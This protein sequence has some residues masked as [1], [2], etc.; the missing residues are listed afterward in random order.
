MIANIWGQVQMV[1]SLPVQNHPR[2][3]LPQDTQGSHA[4]AG[5]DACAPYSRTRPPFQVTCALCTPCHAVALAHAPVPLVTLGY[6]AAYAVATL[7]SRYATTSPRAPPKLSPLLSSNRAPSNPPLAAL[8]LPPPPPPPPPSSEVSGA[9][10]ASA[11]Q[12]QLRRPALSERANRAPPPSHL[13]PRPLN[14]RGATTRSPPPPPPPPPPR[15]RRGPRVGPGA[16]PHA[17]LLGP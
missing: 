7:T 3:C 5:T 9:G 15:N 16:P 8:L 6:Q 1:C 17:S 13:P 11:T 4:A 10:A 2:D 14:G 12:P